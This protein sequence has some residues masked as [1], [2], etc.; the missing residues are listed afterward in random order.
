M[1]PATRPSYQV[2]AHSVL[3]NTLQHPGAIQNH[4]PLHVLGW[5]RGKLSYND[6]ITSKI[7][8]ISSHLRRREADDSNEVI[9][10]ADGY[11]ALFLL[12]ADEIRRNYDAVKQGQP[13]V[14]VSAECNNNPICL[15]GY[16]E[17]DTPMRY[18]N[19]GNYMGTTGQWL[20]S[21]T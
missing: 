13:G 10:F 9:L 8:A 17:S 19:T 15:P 7:G 20:G 18:I 16:P 4:V 2:I 5:G 6:A 21:Y 14:L 3:F 11:D 12:P 1:T